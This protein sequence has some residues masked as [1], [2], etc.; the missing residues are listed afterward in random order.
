VKGIVFDIKRFAIHDGPGIRTTVFLK[1]CTLRCKWCHNPESI[2]R[3][4]QILTMEDKCIGCGACVKAC[5]TGALKLE[6]DR[7]VYD[8]GRCTVCG[9]CAEVCYAGARTLAGYE[10]TVADALG[11]VLR[12]KAFYENSGGG[13]TLSGGEPL[14][15]EAW[16]L[17]FLTRAG[18][19]GLHRCVDSC[20]NVPWE[21]LERAIPLT[22]KFLVDI[23][24]LDPEK[25]RHM[26]GVTNRVILA[27]ARRL[28]ERHEDILWRIPVIPGFNDAEWEI[29]RM[30][31][32]CAELG[33]SRELELMPYHRLGEGKWRRLGW[34][35]ELEGTEAPSADEMAVLRAAVERAGMKS[36]VT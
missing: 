25:H 11:E 15:Q 21:T 7:I 23:K 29:E 1:G 22:E 6:G 34:Q 3:A 18:E 35:Y 17:R 31:A 20:L 5:P 4:R 16:S 12:D 2:L 36:V 10:I 13:V 9:A 28:A 33:S 30:A 19:E 14:A 32:F 26:T 27:N 8:R 24:H